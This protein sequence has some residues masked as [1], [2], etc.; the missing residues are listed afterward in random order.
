MFF[1]VDRER[2]RRIEDKIDILIA[3][4]KAP[5]PAAENDLSDHRE[6]PKF[7]LD[8]KEMQEGMNSLMS[9]DPFRKKRGGDE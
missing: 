6:P 3:A 8:D 5:A 2:L 7:L 4:Q 1:N 9:Y